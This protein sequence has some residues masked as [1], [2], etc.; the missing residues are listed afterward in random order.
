MNYENGACHVSCLVMI[1]V[2]YDLLIIWK[3]LTLCSRKAFWFL[4]VFSFAIFKHLGNGNREAV[5]S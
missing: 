1:L 3:S 5:A 4:R 2:V